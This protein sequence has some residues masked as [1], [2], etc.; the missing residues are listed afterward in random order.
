M[1]YEIFCFVRMFVRSGVGWSWLVWVDQGLSWWLQDVV[2]LVLEDVG[3][4]EG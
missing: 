4:D 3:F 1:F 2:V